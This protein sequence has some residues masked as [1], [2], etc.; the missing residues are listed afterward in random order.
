M[1]A[2]DYYEL[3]GINKSATDKDIKAA[4]RRMARK[5]HPDVNPGD[6]SAESRFKEINAAYEVLSDKDKRAKYDKYGEKWQYAD[7]LDQQAQQQGPYRQ[8][9]SNGDGQS[10]AFN[11]GGDDG[12]MD[13]IFEQLFGSSRGRGG[14]YSRRTQA[15][16]GEDLESNVEITLEE[17]YNGTSR[18]I[19]LQQEQPCPTCRGTG[20]IANLP[21][22]TCKGAGVVGKVARLEVKVPAGVTTGSKV[23]ISGKGQAGGNGGPAGDLYLN[24]AVSPHPLFE[25]QEDDLTVSLPVPLTVAVLGGEVQ[26]PTPKGIK[27]AL[28]IPPE[29][30]NGRIFRLG[31]QGMP[32]LGKATRGDLLVKVNVIL[33]TRLTEKQKELFKQLGELG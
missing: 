23:R 1:A 12:G 14:G 21:C 31:G 9:Y 19:N 28:K 10:Q 33:P 29:T 17:A 8:Y 32:H 3:L 22:S 30:Q 7:Q 2:K 25:R 18:Q 5:Y 13:G 6:K 27:L 15:Q 4:Y 26:V 11:F 20:M 16:R 24:I